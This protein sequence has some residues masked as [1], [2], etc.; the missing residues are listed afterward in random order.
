MSAEVVYAV[1][2][3]LH[4]QCQTE[5]GFDAIIANPPWEVFQTDEKEF[6]QQYDDLI[7][8]KKIDIKAWI[9]QRDKFLKDTEIAQKWLDYCSSYSHVSAFFKASNNYKNQISKVDGKIVSRKVNLYAV[10]FRTML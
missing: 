10:F 3:E 9:K 1:R 5:D 7:K 6:F 4:D 8:K 2:K